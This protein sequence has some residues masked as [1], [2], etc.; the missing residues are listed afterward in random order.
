MKWFYRSTVA[1]RHKYSFSSYNFL[2]L[3]KLDGCFIYLVCFCLICSVLTQHN[4]QSIMTTKPKPSTSEWKSSKIHRRTFSCG[5]VVPRNNLCQIHGSKFA[6]E[7][8]RF[9]AFNMCSHYKYAGASHFTYIYICYQLH[10]DQ[11]S[12]EA[13]VKSTNTDMA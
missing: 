10:H 1:S 4:F 2:V 13:Y 3:C 6:L 11:F 12:C 8:V 7:L 9:P 5:F